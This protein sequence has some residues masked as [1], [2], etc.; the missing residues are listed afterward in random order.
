MKGKLNSEMMNLTH[1]VEKTMLEQRLHDAQQGIA[2]RDVRMEV[3]DIKADT[4]KLWT[5]VA[6]GRD[7]SSTSL[8]DTALNK[9]SPGT[10]G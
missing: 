9:L 3:M 2:V 1:R 6:A 4:S 5:A 7:R 8:A 10:G